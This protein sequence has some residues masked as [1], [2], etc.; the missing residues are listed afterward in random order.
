MKYVT[1]H[2]SYRLLANFSAPRDLDAAFRRLKMPTT[3]IAGDADDLMQSDK[4]G[5]IVRGI[6]PPID[7]KLLPGLGHMDMLH[8][9]AAVESR[10]RAVAGISR[11]VICKCVRPA[12]HVGPAQNID[13]QLARNR[14]L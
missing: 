1:P 9:P 8:V 6:Q 5:D 3:I 11:D 14:E 10:P 4:Y 7:V 12:E 2:Y 13:G